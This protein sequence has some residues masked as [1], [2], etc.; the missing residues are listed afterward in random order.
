VDARGYASATQ[1][2]RIRAGADNRADFVLTAGGTLIIRTVDDRG[3]PVR[4]AQPE[5]MDEQGNFFLGFFPDLQDLMTM[6][7]EEIL[8]KDGVSTNRNLPGGKYR[9]KVSALGYEDEFVNVTVR[10][11]EETEE[12]VPL[13]ESK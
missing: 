2:V 6:G 13:R 5:I 1:K 3:D 4:G 7:F 10:D 11:G 12:T 9:V 8:R